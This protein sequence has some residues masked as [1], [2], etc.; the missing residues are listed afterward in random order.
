M[1]TPRPAYKKIADVVTAEVPVL[2]FAKVEEFIAWPSNVK[3]MRQTNR[4]GV[5]FDKAWID[6]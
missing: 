3:G 4:S 1:R 2:P 5:V 6:K